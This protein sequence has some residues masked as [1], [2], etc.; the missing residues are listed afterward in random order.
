MMPRKLDWSNRSDNR[1]ITRRPQKTYYVT[2]RFG[3]F[4]VGPAIELMFKRIS[5][6]GVFLF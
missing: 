2:N 6:M 3:T 4:P 5:I 1:F